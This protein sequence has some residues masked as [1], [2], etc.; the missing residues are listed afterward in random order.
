M[1]VRPAI[2]S[3]KFI[4]TWYLDACMVAPYGVSYLRYDIPYGG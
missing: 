4:L 1:A 2:E 3:A